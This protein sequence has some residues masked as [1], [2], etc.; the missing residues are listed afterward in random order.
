MRAV[1]AVIWERSESAL[2]RLASIWLWR[3][4]ELIGTRLVPSSALAAAAVMAV[5]RNRRVFVNAIEN[6]AVGG[7]GQRRDRRSGWRRRSRS[8]RS[9]QRGGEHPNT[10]RRAW[11]P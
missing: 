4:P 2:D 6:M 7:T 10:L 11:V 3:S 9:L 8:E 1:S 5:A